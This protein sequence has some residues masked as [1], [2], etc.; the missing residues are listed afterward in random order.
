MKLQ[1]ISGRTQVLAFDKTAR[2]IKEQVEKNPLDSIFVVVPDHAT[3]LVENALIEVLGKG[4]FCVDVVTLNTLCK[5]VLGQSKAQS[6]ISSIGLL[7][8]VQEIII[9]QEQNFRFYKNVK[10]VAIASQIYKTILQLKSSL[11]SVSALKNV[12]KN[13]PSNLIDKMHDIAFVYENYENFLSETVF[14]EPSKFEM[15]IKQIKYCDKVKQSKFVF[16]RFETM[17]KQLEE[18]IDELAKNSKGVLVASVDNSAKSESD[19]EL[20]DYLYSFSSKKLKNNNRFELLSFDSMEEE[21]SFAAQEIAANLDSGIKPSDIVVAVSNLEKYKDTIPRIF[22]LYGININMDLRY[23]GKNHKIAKLLLYFL[24]AVESN[25]DINSA[26]ALAKCGAFDVDFEQ[27]SKLENFCLK[28]GINHNQFFAEVFSDSEVEQTRK[29]I[30]GSL[31][32]Q[33]IQDA[34][35]IGQAV[36]LLA[37][38]IDA[39]NLDDDTVGQKTKDKLQ[40]ILLEI[41]QTIGNEPFVLSNFYTLF[42]TAIDEIK[43]ATTP[44]YFDAVIVQDAFDGFFGRSKLLFVVGASEQ[45]YPRVVSD[46]G[47]IDDSDID[48]LGKN[49]VLEPKISDINKKYLQKTFEHCFLA[50]K[51]I[52]SFVASGDDRA[53]LTMQDLAL[54]FNTQIEHKKNKFAVLTKR[55]ATYLLAQNLNKIR[56]GL[57]PK[58]ANS[59]MALIE[60]LGY[61]EKNLSLPESEMDFNSFSPSQLATYGS[62]PFKHFLSYGLKIKELDTHK[63]K[64]LD[65]GNILHDFCEEYTKSQQQTE[66]IISAKKL[67]A[68]IVSRDKYK[69][70]FLH[71]DNRLTAKLLEEEVSRL[72]KKLDRHSSESEFVVDKIEEEFEIKIGKNKK[73]K[74]KIDRIDVCGDY[75]RVIDYKTGNKQFDLKDVYFGTDF[76]LTGYSIAT[77]DKTKKEIA[78]VYLLPLLN[79]VDDRQSAMLNGYTLR[80]LEVVKKLDKNIEASRS[81]QLIAGLRLTNENGFYSNSKVATKEQFDGVFDYAKKQA[82]EFANEI[83]EGNIEPSIAKKSRSRPCSF[84]DFSNFFCKSVCKERNV[85]KSIVINQFAREVKE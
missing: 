48:Y 74:G 13:L 84:C 44:A 49:F 66:T 10:N 43:I 37:D 76:Q 33:D 35:T 20:L 8:L 1:K 82:T 24:Q 11:V 26:L 73:L 83:L 12:D 41:A 28:Y 4:L 81:S 64:S 46:I 68:N 45:D 30:F 38:M 78:G 32:Y 72:A 22:D 39:I 63:V 47:I 58:E 67:F 15:L 70:T 80:D 51:T 31:P 65:I 3:L 54:I 29:T 2:L 36:S 79:K 42:K 53:S 25:F 71:K 59:V 23:E 18:A 34:S 57:E 19:D 14:D 5:M 69:N 75:A 6:S 62:C 9:K 52:F 61:S 50:D 21:L 17:T 56:Q 7:A 55:Q 27:M 60:V 85:N 16:C 77:I 40:K